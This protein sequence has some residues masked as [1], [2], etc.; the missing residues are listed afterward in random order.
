MQ[1]LELMGT[2]A[3]K[4]IFISGGTGGVGG[5]MAIPIAKAK[6]VLIVITNGA[7]S[8]ERVLKRAD[9]LSLQNRGLCKN[10]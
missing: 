4:T 9:R 5:D 8:A 3:G 7:G 6:K 1:T 2:Q 10:C